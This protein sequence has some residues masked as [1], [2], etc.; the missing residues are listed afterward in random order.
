[1][2]PIP[3]FL[4]SSIYKQSESSFRSP[5]LHHLSTASQA[6]LIS[7]YSSLDS[8]NLHL[9]NSNYFFKSYSPTRKILKSYSAIW[10]FTVFNSKHRF[11]LFANSPIAALDRCKHLQKYQSHSFPSIYLVRFISR[12]CNESSLL[13]P[14]PNCIID[15]SFTSPHLF[16]IIFNCKNNSLLLC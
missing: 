15:L 16:M 3:S 4:F 11:I 8:P 2:T 6:S 13:S 10:S 14:E 9:K 7:P 1:M 12:Y 5:T